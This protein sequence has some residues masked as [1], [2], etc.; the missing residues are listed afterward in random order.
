MSAA[1]PKA[2]P[3]PPYPR[4]ERIRGIRW[5]SEPIRYPGSHGDT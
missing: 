4:S 3:T 2:P 1:D 5:L